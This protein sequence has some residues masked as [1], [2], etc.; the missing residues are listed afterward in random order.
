MGLAER[1]IRQRP[2]AEKKSASVWSRPSPRL[3]VPVP[4]SSPLRH[5]LHPPRQRPGRLP[6]C[7]VPFRRSPLRTPS[8]VFS[9]ART[10]PA[11]GK[12]TGGRLSHRLSAPDRSSAYASRLLLSPLAPSTA[13]FFRV[14]PVTASRVPDGQSRMPARHLRLGAPVRA[15]PQ[16]PSCAGAGRPRAPSLWRGAA[17]LPYQIRVGNLPTTEL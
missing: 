10:T 3:A 17:F 2:C 11:R 14:I 12:R 15:E 4:A 16:D 5:G 8:S 6:A 9:R 7:G 1:D 13:V